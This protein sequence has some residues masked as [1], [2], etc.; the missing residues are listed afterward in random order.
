MERLDSIHFHPLI[1]LYVLVDR[2]LKVRNGASQVGLSDVLREPLNAGRVFSLTTTVL[3]DLLARLNKD[4]QDWRIHFVR[5]A[6]LDM[7]TLPLLKPIDIV[8]RYYSER[9][10]RDEDI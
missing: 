5:T 1:L 4:Y 10:F 8:T 2:Q 7:L 6:G 3:S 9:A